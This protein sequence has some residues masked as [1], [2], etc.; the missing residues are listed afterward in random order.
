M[1]EKQFEEPRN[2]RESPKKR[3]EGTH[4]PGQCSSVGSLQLPPTPSFLVML[5]ELWTHGPSVLHI[6]SFRIPPGLTLCLLTDSSSGNLSTSGVLPSHQPPCTPPHPSSLALP[7]TSSRK[8]PA[9]TPSSPPA[10]SLYGV[11]S[12]PQDITGLDMGP[13]TP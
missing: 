4:P 5:P 3:R 2:R 11:V 7:T 8:P 12:F 9:W 10:L 6:Q 13:G 1:T